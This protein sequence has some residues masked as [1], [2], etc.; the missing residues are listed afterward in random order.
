MPQAECGEQAIGVRCRGHGISAQ[1]V[2]RWR[3]K[4][5]GLTVPDAQRWR[6]LSQEKARRTR[7][8][9]ERDLEVDALKALRAK[10]S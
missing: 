4:F 1:P 3:Q 7:L 6:D 2:Y 9:A 5:S 8:L 10:Q